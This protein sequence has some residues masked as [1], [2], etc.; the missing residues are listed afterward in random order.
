M[1]GLQWMSLIAFPSETKSG[2]EWSGSE[3]RDLFSWCCKFCC[4]PLCCSL[5][6]G[7]VY[8]ARENLGTR[9]KCEAWLVIHQP[10]VNFLVTDVLWV[11]RHVWKCSWIEQCLDVGWEKGR[12]KTFAP[13]WCFRDLLLFEK[14]C[15][16]LI[17]EGVLHPHHPP[18]SLGYGNACKTGRR[19]QVPWG[20]LQA[21]RYKVKKPQLRALQQSCFETCGFLSVQLVGEMKMMIR[22]C[23]SNHLAETSV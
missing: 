15:A 13:V 18:Y 17:S 4:F 5:S 8:K 3:N 20:Y 22:V 16:C 21:D 9:T 1:E 10:S 6:W 23:G 2:L 14:C 12:N 11:H 19:K 7:Q